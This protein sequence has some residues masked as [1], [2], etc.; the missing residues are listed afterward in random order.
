MSTADRVAFF[1]RKVISSRAGSGAA[2]IAEGEETQTLH[3]APRTRA[4]ARGG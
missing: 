1:M 3:A 2:K 4:R